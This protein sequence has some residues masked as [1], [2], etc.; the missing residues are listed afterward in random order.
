[1]RDGRA[2]PREPEAYL[3]QYVEGPRGEPA[4]MP[5]LLLSLAARR[6]GVSAVAVEAFMNDAGE[7]FRSGLQPVQKMPA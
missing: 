6:S 3:K 4:Q 7:A 2:E 1:M 5:S